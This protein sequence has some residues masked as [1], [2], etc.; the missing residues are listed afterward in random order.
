MAS[1][2][3]YALFDGGSTLILLKQELARDIGLIGVTQPLTL[4]GVNATTMEP[5]SECVD[6]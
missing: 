3:T 6:L 1:K 2:R 5:N 4:A